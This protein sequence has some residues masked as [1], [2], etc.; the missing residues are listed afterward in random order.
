MGEGGEGGDDFVHFE[1]CRR[2]GL[3]G[4]GGGVGWGK[5]VWSG[6]L[7]RGRG[8]GLDLGLL[9]LGSDAG[10]EWPGLGAVNVQS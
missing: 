8:F 2:A 9:L 10:V 3:S 6:G 1:V 5:G 7:R 4:R